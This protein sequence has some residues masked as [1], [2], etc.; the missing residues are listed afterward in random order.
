[1]V[2]SSAFTIAWS[3]VCMCL[4]VSV[5]SHY[6]GWHG[7]CG[8]WCHHYYLYAMPTPDLRSLGFNVA[9]RIAGPLDDLRSH[10]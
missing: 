1:M 2:K 7:R 5:R 10:S 8:P 3:F 9:R 4:V 6:D